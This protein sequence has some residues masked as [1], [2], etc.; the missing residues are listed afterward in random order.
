M[1]Y[2]VPATVLGKRAFRD[3]LGDKVSHI[4]NT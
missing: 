3:E 2:Y 1:E 4:T